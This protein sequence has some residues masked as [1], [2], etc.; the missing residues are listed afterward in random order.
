LIAPEWCLSC[1]ALSLARQFRRLTFSFCQRL[2]IS[3]ASRSSIECSPACIDSM[4]RWPPAS[5]SAVLHARGLLMSRPVIIRPA[6]VDDAQGVLKTHSAAVHRTAARQYASDILTAWAASLDGTT[7]GGWPALLRRSQNW[8]SSPRS[9]QRLLASD[10]SCR[11]TVSFSR[12]T[13]TQIL[14]A[15]AWQPNLGGA[16]RPSAATQASRVDH[17]RLA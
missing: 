13:F 16:G 3:L 4:R 5:S 1:R 15:K 2:T 7:C 11:K 10:Q 12:S 9:V 6:I 14:G 8:F 17:G